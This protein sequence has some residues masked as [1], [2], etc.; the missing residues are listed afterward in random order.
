MGW[1]TGL[2]AVCCCVTCVTGSHLWMGTVQY[3]VPSKKVRLKSPVVTHTPSGWAVSAR[4]AGHGTAR[5]QVVLTA[6]LLCP[7]PS[8]GWQAMALHGRKWSHVAKLVPG[9][10]DVQCRERYMNC[11][12][13]GGWLGDWAGRLLHLGFGGVVLSGTEGGPAAAALLCPVAS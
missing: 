4:W 9:R 11:L 5:P 3:T 2:A 10:T 7:Q 6:P 8:P 13:P 1:D 12:N